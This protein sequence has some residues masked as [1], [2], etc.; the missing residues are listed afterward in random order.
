MM[1]SVNQTLE[2]AYSTS[3]KVWVS[4]EFGMLIGNMKFNT[5]NEKGISIH[6]ILTAYFSI[7]QVQ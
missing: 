6:T 7:H 1:L 5:Q 3:S 4:S 2:Q